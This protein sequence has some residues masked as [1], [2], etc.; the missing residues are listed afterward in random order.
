MIGLTPTSCYLAIKKYYSKVLLIIRM[1]L[2]MKKRHTTSW[3]TRGRGEKCTELEGKNKER[4]ENEEEKMNE[5]MPY[6]LIMCK[7]KTARTAAPT[8][9]TKNS[10]A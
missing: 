2:E 4:E 8:T 7:E 3:R 1:K 6:L 5:A 9:L 10:E